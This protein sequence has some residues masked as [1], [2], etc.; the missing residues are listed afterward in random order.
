MAAEIR[1]MRAMGQ[2]DRYSCC[3]RRKIQ[4][5]CGSLCWLDGLQIFGRSRR[6]QNILTGHPS[7]RVPERS[8][9]GGV[10]LRDIW[11]TF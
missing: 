7:S 8:Q 5:G 6:H 3:Q 11:R 4:V 2:A 10:R 9:P 1:D